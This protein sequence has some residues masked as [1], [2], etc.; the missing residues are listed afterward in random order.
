[1]DTIRGQSFHPRQA[2]WL[3]NHLIKPHRVRDVTGF[4]TN[5]YMIALE[6]IP[7]KLIVKVLIKRKYL[8]YIKKFQKVWYM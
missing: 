2:Y 8:G 3:S 1:M 7:F 6:E 4:L 5:N